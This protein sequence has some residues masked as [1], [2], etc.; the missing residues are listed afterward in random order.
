MWHQLKIQ[1]M[2]RGLSGMEVVSGSTAEDGFK[3]CLI[4]FSVLFQQCVSS[5]DRESWK[6]RV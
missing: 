2:F 4:V 3:V 6:N 5:L 1:E